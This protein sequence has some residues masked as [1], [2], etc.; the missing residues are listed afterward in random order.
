MKGIPYQ[1]ATRASDDRL[2]SN[3]IVAEALAKQAAMRP[4]KSP[5]KLL[6]VTPRMPKAGKGRR[7]NRRTV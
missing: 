6:V 2:M 7:R 1:Q 3:P 5:P 4:E